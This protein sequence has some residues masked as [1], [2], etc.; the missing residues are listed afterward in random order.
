MPTKDEADLLRLLQRH[1]EVRI[2][3]SRN[4]EDV[5]DALCLKTLDKQVGRFISPPHS[6]PSR[7]Y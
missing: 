4:S 1:H 7:N 2:L 3:F 5:L 6:Q